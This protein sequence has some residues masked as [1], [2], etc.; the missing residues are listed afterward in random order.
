MN[1]KEIV[2]YF[3]IKNI[4]LTPDALKEI[5]KKEIELENLIKLNKFVIEVEDIFKEKYNLNFKIIKNLSSKPK[6]VTTQDFIKFYTSKYE[7]MKKIFIEKMG[8]NFLSF[9][10]IPF[11]KKEIFLIGI[12]KDINDKTIE[13]E[14]TTASIKVIF[15]RK[16]DNLELDDAIAVKGNC[17]AKIVYASDLFFPDIP[18]K[19]EKKSDGM[20]CFLSFPLTE[21]IFKILQKSKCDY[22]FI[23]GKLDDTEKFENYVEKYCENKKIFVTEK[24]KDYPS[25]PSFFSKKNIISL[26]NPAI[27][28]INDVKILNISDFDIQMLKKRYLG[29]TKTILPED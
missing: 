24:K 7:K 26:S 3:F 16:I 25:M 28:E 8:E 22:I 23:T 19:T 29:K 9:N 15:D 6:E 10:K 1:E 11:S 27:V 5:I 12:V 14:D 2:K 20:I 17:E 4:L 18:N 21:N 13:L